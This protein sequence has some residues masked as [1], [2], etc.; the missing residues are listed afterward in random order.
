MSEQ[1]WRDLIVGDRMQV[2][3]EFAERVRQSGFSNQQWSLV[4][5]AVELELHGSG[6]DAELVANTS[7]VRDIMPELERVAEQLNAQPGGPTPSGGG[8]VDSLKSSL[9]LGGSSVDE[10][11]IREAEQLTAAYASALEAHLRENGK[12]ARVVELD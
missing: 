11:T 3:Q 1:E 2:D 7:R 9:G 12:W 6:E 10:D 5:T 4:M 8:L